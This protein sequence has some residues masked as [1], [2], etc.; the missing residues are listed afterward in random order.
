MAMYAWLQ[1]AL[2]AGLLYV[3]VL[4]A[5][6]VSRIAD[7]LTV[8]ASAVSAATR[9]LTDPARRGLAVHC[10][11]LGKLSAAVYTNGDGSL[12]TSLNGVSRA[13][14]QQPRS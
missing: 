13:L 10:D 3:L 7:G 14:M 8:L 9:Q 6:A 2:F 1:F 5:A 11:E 4:L 12:T